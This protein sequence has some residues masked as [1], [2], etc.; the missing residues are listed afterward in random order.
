MALCFSL[1]RRSEQR[2]DQAQ[3]EE[4][5]AASRTSHKQGRSRHRLAGESPPFQRCCGREPHAATLDSGRSDYWWQHTNFRA[6]DLGCIEA[7][8]REKW[9]IVRNSSNLI[10]FRC[11]GTL[12]NPKWTRMEVQICL[13]KNPGLWIRTPGKRLI[14]CNAL[15]QT[16]FGRLVIGHIEADF[17]KYSFQNVSH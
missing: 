16:Y 10:I 6:P 12:P 9:R 17:G 4:K 2:A 1:M 7:D 3:P 15:L 8:R 14:K 5:L 13:P 11:I